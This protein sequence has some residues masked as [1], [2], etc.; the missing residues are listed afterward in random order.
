VNEPASA[1]VTGYLGAE[2]RVA[3]V[4]KA[5]M[6]FWNA[7][8]RGAARTQDLDRAA[9]F[10]GNTVHRACIVMLG[11]AALAGSPVAAQKPSTA[12]AQK[13]EPVAR[14]PAGVEGSQRG[15]L[16]AS[17]AAF[18]ESVP[19]VAEHRYRLSA[20]IRPLLLFWIGRGNVG[21]A[22]LAWHAG[23]DGTLG[24][25]M[26][27]GS[28]PDR[29][30]MHVNRWGY[31][32]EEVKGPDAAMVG[33]MKQSDEES[34]D[35]AKA[36]VGKK[37]GEGYAFKL[38]RTRVTGG[39]SSAVVTSGRFARDYTYLDLK[40][41]LAAFE[42]GP[43][44]TGKP[45]QVR[46]DAGARPGFL[47]AVASLIHDSVVS[48]R[49]SGVSGLSAQSVSYPYNGKMYDLKAARPRFLQK[50]RYGDRTYERLLRTDFRA[51][52]K[53]TG[54]EESFCVVY[55]TDG[56]IAEVPVYFTYQPRWWFKAEVFLEK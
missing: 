21:D 7:V 3:V 30:P 46:L 29:A 36:S 4:R 51:R 31:V 44:Q 42:S 35:E 26:L 15:E 32:R 50:E 22:R 5:R 12:T 25:E 18:S 2:T 39:T 38:I 43:T 33:V 23:A 54:D 52:N 8:W 13:Q 19:I 24:W 48:Y 17:L 27:I 34:L 56:N 53:V 1:V 14:T 47:A 55:G 11:L 41:L 10:E 20:S 40:E 6:L 37:E 45:K 28:D 49:R 16:I 9:R